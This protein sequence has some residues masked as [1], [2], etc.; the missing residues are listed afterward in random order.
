ML[1]DTIKQGNRYKVGQ[2][3]GHFSFEIWDA[4]ML[5]MDKYKVTRLFQLI[6]DTD[7]VP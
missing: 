6:G 7:T 4:D 3:T 1:I 2:H 5:T